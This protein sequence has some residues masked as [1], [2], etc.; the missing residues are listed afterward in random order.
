ML[1]P[2]PELIQAR[3]KEAVHIDRLLPRHKIG[4]ALY[5]SGM[6]DIIRTAKEIKEGDVIPIRERATKAEIGRLEECLAWV[7][8]YLS[9]DK[10]RE[11]YRKPMWG[12]VMASYKKTS[13]RAYCRKIGVGP[14]TGIDRAM[15][16]FVLIA[17]GLRKECKT[18]DAPGDEWSG[19]DGGSTGIEESTVDFVREGA[20]WMSSDVLP[21]NAADEGFRLVAIAAIERRRREKLGIA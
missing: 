18:V 8:E 3:F 20:S 17:D 19:Q 14:Q 13:F 2:T 15:R 12:Y 11:K 16:A 4:P 21:E 10:G 1:E 9:D 6:P 5:G 7:A